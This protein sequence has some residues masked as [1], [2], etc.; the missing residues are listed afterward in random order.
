M[1]QNGWFR[2]EAGRQKRNSANFNR[3][4][5]VPQEPS[6][7][8]VTSLPVAPVQPVSPD[9]ELKSTVPEPACSA[10]PI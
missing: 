10:E 3:P 6:R 8:K 2:L 5:A 1:D 9:P 4:R 7:P